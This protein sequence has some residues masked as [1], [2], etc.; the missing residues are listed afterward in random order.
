MENRLLT[1]FFSTRALLFLHAS[2]DDIKQLV[3]TTL[4]CIF[5]DFGVHHYQVLNTASS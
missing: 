5:L 3:E 2:N 1:C 4:Y